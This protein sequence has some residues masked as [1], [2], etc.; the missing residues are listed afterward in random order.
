MVSYVDVTKA[1]SDFAF[2]L[3][4]NDVLLLRCPLLYATRFPW[5]VSPQLC[6]TFP[7]FVL[8]EELGQH[9]PLHRH[10]GLTVHALPWLCERTGMIFTLPG[11]LNP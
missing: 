7:M 2:I 1:F 8:S 3:Y 10:A 9:E 6:L 4:L 11:V 5:L